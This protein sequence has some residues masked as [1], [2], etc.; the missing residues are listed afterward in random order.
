VPAVSYPSTDQSM[1]ITR[2]HPAADTALLRVAGEVDMLTSPDLREAITG[3]LSSSLRRLIID[4][5][6]VEFLGTSGLA[7]LVETRTQAQANSVELWLV[8]S[9]RNVLRP[10]QIAGLVSLFRIADSVSATISDAGSSG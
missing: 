2:E 8:C 1:T 10:L 4:L 3:Q 5:D 7:A 9:N 6:G